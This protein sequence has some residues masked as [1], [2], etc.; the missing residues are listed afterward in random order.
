MSEMPFGNQGNAISPDAPDD[1]LALIDFGTGIERRFTYGDLRRST[2]AI[3]RELLSRG[4]KRGDRV[5]ILSLNRAEYLFSFLGIMQA[6]LVAV[7]VNHK[8]PADTMGYIVGD[9]DARI[10]LGDAPRLALAPADIAKIC[11]DDDFGQLRDEGPFV[12]LQMRPEEPAMFLYTSG[13]SGRPKGVVLSHYSHIWVMSA[14]ARVRGPAGQRS[15]VAAPLYHMN[16]LGTCQGTFAH[17]D[18]IVLLPQFTAASYIEAVAHCRVDLLTSVP[19]MIAMMLRERELLARADLSSVRVVRMGSAPLTQS[20]I[21]QVRSVF[22]T[23]QI[24]NG[25]GTTEIGP[26]VFGPHPDGIKQPELSPGYPHRAVQLRLVRDGREVADEGVLEARC[27]ALMTHY[28]KLPE[29]TAK[30]MTADGYYRTGDVFRRDADGFF[31]FVGREDDMFVCGG[32]N[33]FPGDVEK[34]LERHPGIHQA[35][36]IPMPDDLKG[37]KPIAFVVRTNG[38]TLDE[39]AVKAYALANAPAYQHPRRVVFIDEMPL[40]GTNKIDKRALVQRMR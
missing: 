27:G 17:G 33:I 7:P 37:H 12:P 16:G 34:M 14:R 8:L 36:V 4:L 2:G 30:A 21:D 15:L 31:F 32:E 40:A 22:P 25:Y 29:A 3:A 26:I 11:F 20:L 39:D 13:S 19:T 6:G 35:A 23:A 1:R 9:C 10:A 28:H 38:S 18:T 24:T 5:A